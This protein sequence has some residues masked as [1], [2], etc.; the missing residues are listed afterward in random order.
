MFE[1]RLAGLFDDDDEP[2]QPMPQPASFLAKGHHAKGQGLFGDEDEVFE[3]SSRTAYTHV[4]LL[5]DVQLSIPF[6]LLSLTACAAAVCVLLP[7]V[8]C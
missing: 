8:S 4:T 5:T 7:H 2:S 6:T 1:S 3:V